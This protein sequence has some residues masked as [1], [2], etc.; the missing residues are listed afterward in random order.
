MPSTLRRWLPV[1]LLATP[2]WTAAAQ[3]GPLDSASLAR[4]R[5]DRF[6]RVEL[7]DLGR[8]Q[9]QVTRNSM[10]DLYLSQGEQERQIPTAQIQ[11]AWVRGRAT[12]TGAIVGGVLGLGAGLFVGAL[13]NGLC[14]STSC[15]DATLPA[16]LLGTLAG[17]G[18][19]AIV[20]SAIPKWHEV[21]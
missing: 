3:G 21:K 10:T 1:L 18:V 16:A 20:G 4:L 12:R 15:G 9:G 5:P 11:R 7:P 6:V 19:G 17:A 14:E 13:A 8:I 2:L